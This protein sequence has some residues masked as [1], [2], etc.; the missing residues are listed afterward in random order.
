MEPSVCSD[1]EAVSTDQDQ[2][3]SLNMSVSSADDLN[4]NDEDMRLFDNN[5]SR[6]NANN[7]NKNLLF[8]E[9]KEPSKATARTA[10]QASLQNPGSLISDFYIS[11]MNYAMRYS[12]EYV[13]Q[14]AKDLRSRRQRQDSMNHANQ[15]MTSRRHLTTDATQTASHTG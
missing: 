8:Q 7:N 14:V 4:I 11:N 9:S 2:D 3:D 6:H 15:S 5:N 13:Q 12:V 10:Q 1:S